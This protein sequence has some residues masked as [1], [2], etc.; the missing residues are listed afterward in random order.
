MKTI[1][2]V[3][4]GC[5]KNLIDSEMILS[6]FQN[7]DYKI[8]QDPSLADVII[9]NT[10]GFIEDAK[11][12]A[13]ETILEMAKYHGLLV[14]CGC[15]V[16][17]NLKELKASIP[18]VDLW[19]PLKDYPVMNKKLE[20]LLKTNDI[21]P[22]NPLK[23]TISTPSYCAYL[24]I[25][26]GCDNFCSFCAIPYIRGR[27][28]SRNFDEVLL[29][30]KGLVKKGV[31]EIS[32]V[33]QD[34]MH[35]G[36]DFPNKKPN[37]LDLLHELDELGFYSIR[38]LYLYPEEISE[39]ELEFIA[40][41][42]SIDHYFDVPIQ[43]ANDHLLK[44][45]NRHGSKEEMLNLFKR[46]KELMPDAVLRTT[47]ISGF[48]GENE[49]DQKDTIAF[50][51]EVKFDHLGVFTYSHEEGTAAYKMPDQV[52]EKIKKARRDE[53]MKLQ[54]KISYERNKGH[55]GEIM[56][57]LVTGFDPK[58]NLYTLRSYWNAPD[59][60]DGNIYFASKTPLKSGEIVKVKIK[61]AFIYDLLGE[62]L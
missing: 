59:E 23:R 45:M 19:V 13:I 9:V 24:R 33:S 34:P 57:G 25:S 21:A 42:K 26:E 22:I 44:L 31:K 54:Q 56:E 62:A 11:K 36:S 37:M 27:M 60:I 58:R 2:L 6:M 15:F 61:S 48:P 50:I 55:V 28:V 47:L 49:E 30:A 7:G 8:T 38:L 10:C 16:E 3:S 4:L 53:I 46:I 35:Y 12:E 20:E 17:R 41:S 1:G 43:C 39:E 18:E 29:E 51:K 5:A 52:P 14:V 32:L 40:K